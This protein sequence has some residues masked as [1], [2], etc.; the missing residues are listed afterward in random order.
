MTLLDCSLPHS[1]CSSCGELLP[2]SATVEHYPTLHSSW[3]VVE[4]PKCR[5]CTPFQL[6]LEAANL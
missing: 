1:R 6:Q 5:T 3:I 2:D 4:C